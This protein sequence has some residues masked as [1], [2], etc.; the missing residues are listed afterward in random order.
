[1]EKIVNSN[2]K[3]VTNLWGSLLIYR[4]GSFRRGVIK[5]I[6]SVYR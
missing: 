6:E 3:L 4:K 5:T 2:K 1:M